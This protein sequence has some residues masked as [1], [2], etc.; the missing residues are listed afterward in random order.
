MITMEFEEMKKVWDSQ[1]N[2][3]IYGIN[4]SALHNRILSK[5]Q[6]GIHITNVSE[7][8]LIVVNIS[9]GF[10]ILVINLFRQGANVFMYLLSAWMICVALVLLYSR[11]RRMKESDRFDRSMR[12]DLSHAISIATYQVHISRL[13]RWNILPIGILT[14]LGVWSSGKS[15]WLALGMLVFFILTNYL[16]GWEHNIYASRKREL[17]A[18]QTKLEKIEQGDDL[19]ESHLPDK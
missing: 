9:A 5:K 2:E 4:E 13:M 8:L 11:I 12:G 1:N 10:F 16:S 14:I 17:E 7:L 15:V 19:S 18:L 3:P 6:K